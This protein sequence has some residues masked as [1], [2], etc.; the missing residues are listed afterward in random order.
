V[1]RFTPANARTPQGDHQCDPLEV[2][3]LTCG[4]HVIL[5]N[6]E[7][8]PRSS[9][10]EINRLHSEI[11][12]AAR[13]T[14]EKAIRIG[15]LLTEQKGT[16]N[17]GEWLPWLKANIEF[18]VATA[19][20]YMGIF[21]RR[22]DPKFLN[23][24]NMS[25]AYKLLY[26]TQ[27]RKQAPHQF[28]PPTKG[29]F[30]LIV[31][32]P[33]WHYDFS[34]KDRAIENQYPTATVEEICTHSPDSAADSILFLWRTAPKNLEALEVMKSWGFTYRTEAI[35]DKEIIGMGY[36]FRGQHETLMV[37]TKGNASPPEDFARVGS[38]FRSKRT[39]HSCKPESVY[40]WINK[41]FQNLSKLEMYARK[42][43]EGWATWGK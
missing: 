1:R 9:A 14:I 10:Q 6:M 29:P 8:T 39:K 35:W 23:V 11:C 19:G 22:D 18:S 33:P 27:S 41:A 2:H 31:A 38:V 34:E 16:L 30:D 12:S 25:D 20:N 13:T 21:Q 36:W 40:Q 32:D 15:E 3:C 37:G 7:L 28:I 26:G 17:H 5:V 24:R 4:M 42:P 43:R